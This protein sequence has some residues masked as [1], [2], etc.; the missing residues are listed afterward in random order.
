M[1]AYAV[2]RCGIQFVREKI[3]CPFLPAVN[4]VAAVPIGAVMA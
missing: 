2:L 1:L 3:H 4:N